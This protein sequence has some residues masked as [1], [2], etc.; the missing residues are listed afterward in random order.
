M[1]VPHKSNFFFACNELVWLPYRAKKKGWNYWGSPKIE[2]SIER[3]NASS[4][5]P[6][7]QVRRGGLWAIH[8]GLKRGAIGNTLGE[9]HWKLREHIGNPFGNLKGTCWEQ[10]KNEKT[11]SPHPKLKRK[12]NQGTLS[13][14]LSL[15]IGC[16]YF[17]FPKLLVTIFGI[18]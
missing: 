15:P 12:K 17:W 4:F 11:S 14:C 2:D 9:Q 5:G 10:R 16:M 6:P 3:C 18:G 8:M 7:I 1:G 13:A